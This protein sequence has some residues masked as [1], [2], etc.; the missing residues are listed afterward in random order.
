MSQC[1]AQVLRKQRN[2]LRQNADSLSA[3]YKFCMQWEHAKKEV[4][5]VIEKAVVDVKA[6]TACDICY[7]T[8]VQDF[9]LA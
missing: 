9:F 8:P 4:L 1:V 2:T 6:V 5:C 7:S 3:A